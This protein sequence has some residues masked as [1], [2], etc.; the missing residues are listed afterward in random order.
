M[1][2]DLK[3]ISELILKNRF[4]NFES[5]F[6]DYFSD[7]ES[8]KSKYEKFLLKWFDKEDFDG[9]DEYLY[10]EYLLIIYGKYVGKIFSVDW[11]GE[12]YK[13]Q[14]KSSLTKILKTYDK[15]TFKWNLKKFE[16][17]LK[18]ENIKRGEY[19]GLLFGALDK[20]LLKIDF[21]LL[22]IE[23]FDDEY[24]YTILP[25]SEIKSALKMKGKV[26]CTYD[27]KTY[28]I[29][30]TNLGINKSKVMLY[31]KN[32]HK[33]ELKEISKYV[34]NLPVLV[35][36]GNILKIKKLEKELKAMKCEYEIREKQLCTTPCIKHS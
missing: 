4:S 9:L 16:S 33:I 36:S 13:G 8:F 11:S 5:L 7:L 27:S 35:E 30:I 28:D 29:E 1:D 20:E 18:Q 23:L 14:V 15:P 10:P 26:F 31:L 12:E 17:S 25:K 34:E 32:K 6:N 3:Q 2:N 24:Y 21:Q 22:F 19:I